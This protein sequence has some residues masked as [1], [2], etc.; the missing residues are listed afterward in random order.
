MNSVPASRIVLYCF[1]GS[2]QKRLLDYF[3]GRGV[4]GSRIELVPRTLPAKYF[5]KYNEIDIALDTNPFPGGTTTCDALWMGVPVV[6]LAGDTSLSRGGVSILSN[7]GLS[8]LIANSR[9]QYVEIATGLAKNVEG[10]AQY[11]S[12]LRQRM[13]ASPLMNAPQHARDIEAAYRQMWRDWCG[14]SAGLK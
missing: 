14:A 1:E 5:A 13:A 3:A 8:E 12:T 10:I 2:Q 11:R 9:E 6:T 4:E 7:V